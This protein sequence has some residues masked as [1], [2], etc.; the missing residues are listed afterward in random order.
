[1]GESGFK[2]ALV[3]TALQVACSRCGRGG[4][5]LATEEALCL[6][7]ALHFSQGPLLLG[8]GGH[9]SQQKA[10]TLEGT[11]CSHLLYSRQC[12]LLKLWS[13]FSSGQ[14]G[15]MSQGCVEGRGCAWLYGGNDCVGSLRKDEEKMYSLHLQRSTLQINSESYQPT[16]VLLSSPFLSLPISYNCL[17]WWVIVSYI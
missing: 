9:H 2:P 15:E 6:T 13:T 14:W 11:S 17:R 1:M 3:S 12:C 16:A 7:R 10:V 5:Q 4:W 8:R